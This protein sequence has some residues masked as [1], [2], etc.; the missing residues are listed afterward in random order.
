MADLPF[1]PSCPGDRYRQEYDPVVRK[2]GIIDLVPSGKTDL[3]EFY[4][5]Q[6]SACDM[7]LIVS[8]YLQGDVS[9]LSRTQGL[10]MDVASMPRT[11][12]E[13]LQRVLDGRRFFDALP[14][15]VKSH[16][17]NDFNQWFACAGTDEWYKHMDIKPGDLKS[18]AEAPADVA[19]LPSFKS[20]ES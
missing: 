15:D 7:H 16:F 19:P 3:Q 8:R 12:A 5:S 18:R 4:N 1:S 2:D 9:V 13:M 20:D 17:N 11:P 10:Y 14:S 6:A